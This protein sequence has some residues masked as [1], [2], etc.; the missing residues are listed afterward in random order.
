M[1]YR[2]LGNTGLKVSILGFGAG[3]IGDLAIEDNNVDKIL[4]FAL[5]NGINLIDTARG[6][7]AS[8]DRIGKFISHRRNEFVL[9]TKIGY[10]IEGLEDWSYECIIAG[11]DEAL[12]LL[13]TDYIDLVHLHSCPFEILQRGEAILALQ[14]AVKTGKVKVAAYSGENDELKFAVESNVFQSVQTSFN[15]CDQRNIENIFPTSIKKQIG[16]IAKRPIANAPWR[17]D[18]QPRGRYA[19][20]YWLRWKKMNV[21]IGMDWNEAAL[22]FTAFTKGIDTC[23]VGTTSIKHLKRNIEIINNGKLPEE[24]YF[25]LRNA[26]IQNDDGWTGQV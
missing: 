16:V 13:R 17:F 2:I 12:R 6:Y 24:I 3:E 7:N 9:S 21:D 19:E 26:F 15:I 20:E 10:G 11:V 23:I 18:E 25:T 8:E 5:D 22:R 14:N 1:I 4:N